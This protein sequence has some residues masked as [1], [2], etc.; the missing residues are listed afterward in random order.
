MT[1]PIF[2]SSP[3]PIS[4]KPTA[5]MMA[6]TASAIASVLFLSCDASP[7]GSEDA[8]YSATEPALSGL[9]LVFDCTI[10]DVAM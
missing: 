9:P 3:K 5:I 4:R 8:M 6:W 7:L 2:S 10:V 1:I